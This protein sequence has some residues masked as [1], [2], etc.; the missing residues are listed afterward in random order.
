MEEGIAHRETTNSTLNNLRYSLLKVKQSHYRPGQAFTVPGGRGSQIS[1]QSVHEVG[2]VVSPTHQPPLSPRKYS[3]YSF[4]L[5]AE[6]NPG[7]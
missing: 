3:W 6:S 5:E 7:P 1:R 2:K 4:L